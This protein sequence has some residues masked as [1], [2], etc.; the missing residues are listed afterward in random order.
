MTALYLAIGCLIG[1][2]LPRNTEKHRK[3]L[4]AEYQRGKLDGRRLL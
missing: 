3:A 2:V 1:F 4:N